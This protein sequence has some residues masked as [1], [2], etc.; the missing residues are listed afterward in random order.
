MEL[1]ALKAILPGGPSNSGRWLATNKI[2]NAYKRGDLRKLTKKMWIHLAS[3]R[4]LPYTEKMNFQP[5]LYQALLVY[6]A[7]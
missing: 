4:L 2:L 5:K 6:P 1:S 7:G 3:K